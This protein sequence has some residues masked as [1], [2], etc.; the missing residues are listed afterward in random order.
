MNLSD[1]FPDLFL[2]RYRADFAQGDTLAA[3]EAIKLCNRLD[4]P[5]PRWAR[6]HLS[7]QAL[8][9][10]EPQKK[11][12]KHSKPWTLRHDRANQRAVLACITV[13]RAAG[14]RGDALGEK[15]GELLR[16]VGLTYRPSYL[17]KARRLI[18]SQ[19]CPSIGDYEPFL[20]QVL[21]LDGDEPLPEVSHL[22]RDCPKG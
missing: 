17:K 6:E 5:Y 1:V 15:A 16:G 2:E 20:R 21:V 19:V 10:L 13:C 7:T 11:D 3:W 22:E 4:K 12:G 8:Q 14:Y 9:E 18:P